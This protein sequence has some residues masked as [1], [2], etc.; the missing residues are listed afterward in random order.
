MCDRDKFFAFQQAVREKA[1]EAYSFKGVI[2]SWQKGY[3][4]ESAVNYCRI[5]YMDLRET[6]LIIES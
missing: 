1:G 3:R 2:E 5:L 4:V 6:T